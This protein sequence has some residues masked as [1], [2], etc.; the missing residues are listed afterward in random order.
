MWVC[1]PCDA[2]AVCLALWSGANGSSKNN[3][4]SGGKEERRKVNAESRSFA[5]LRMTRVS[6]WSGGPSEPITTSALVHSKAVL[7]QLNFGSRMGTPLALLRHLP[8]G[9]RKRP[10]P[11]IESEAHLASADIRGHAAYARSQS[12]A[13]KPLNPCCLCCNQ[14]RQKRLVCMVRPRDIHRRAH[15]GTVC[16]PRAVR[17]A[18]GHHQAGAHGLFAPVYTPYLP[19]HSLLKG[20]AEVFDDRRIDSPV[21][22]R[23]RVRRTHETIEGTLQQFKGTVMHMD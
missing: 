13:G 9:P 17:R 6:N 11:A 8:I 3:G 14:C 5:L 4:S 2:G 10:V 19:L 18:G 1:L 16:E 12:R 21:H 23:K 15:G 22:Q 20:H 7:H